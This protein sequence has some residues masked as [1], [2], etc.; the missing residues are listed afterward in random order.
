M[1]NQIGGAVGRISSDTKVGR[2][3][4]KRKPAS[5][6]RLPRGRPDVSSEPG[7]LAR[8]C[9]I[10]TRF[11]ASTQ[12]RCDVESSIVRS[13]VANGTFGGRARI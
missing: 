5:A 3:T 8:F 2:M 9:I 7:S 10:A 13:R 6:M 1:P 11:D 4:R 12:R